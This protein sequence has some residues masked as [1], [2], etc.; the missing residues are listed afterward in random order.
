MSK[1]LELYGKTKDF[2]TKW[3]FLA[4]GLALAILIFLLDSKSKTVKQLNDEIQLLKLGKEL[5]KLKE[6]SAQSEEEFQKSAKRYDDL[7]RLHPEL[8]DR[9][10][11]GSG[12]DKPAA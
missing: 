2:L 1:L 9:V 5:D 4:S 8:F 6:R 10:V 11:N 7:K 3:W 12:P